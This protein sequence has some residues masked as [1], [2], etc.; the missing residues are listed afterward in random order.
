MAKLIRIKEFGGPEVLEVQDV[1]LGEPNQGDAAGEV[2]A[3][4]PS[5]TS[6]SSGPRSTPGSRI[7]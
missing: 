1:Y 6:A 2:V 7:E 5:V 4:G 3:V